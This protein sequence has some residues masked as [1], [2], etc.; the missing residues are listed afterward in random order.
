[1]KATVSLKKNREFKRLYSKGKR[2]VSPY[3]ALY[4]RKNGE[5]RTRLGIT[6]GV[7]LGGAVVRNRVRRRIREIFRLAEPRIAPGY[8]IVV[9]ARTM[10]V[11]S[12]FHEQ[13]RDLL[14]LLSS[15]GLILETD[16]GTGTPGNQSA[17][18]CGNNTPAQKNM[19][20]RI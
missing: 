17:A 6:T 15:G 2:N 14:R 16:I 12:G 8:D 11:N 9:V 3:F 7:K 19:G 18:Q 13:K 5:K 10:A 20:D 4:Y 1:V